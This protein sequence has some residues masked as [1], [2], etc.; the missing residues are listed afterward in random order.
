MLNY[1]GIKSDLLSFVYDGATT[2][3]GRFMPGSHIPI[4]ST[5]YL[6]RTK[7]DYVI[8]LPWN[9]ANEV[10]EQNAI[11]KKKGVKFIIAVPDIKIL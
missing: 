7:P 3:Q 6:N 8:I 10:K 2:K 4:L 1:S 5:K 11:L 9:I